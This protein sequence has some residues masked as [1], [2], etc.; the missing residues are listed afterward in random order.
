MIKINIDR[1]MA[2]YFS[3]TGKKMEMKDLAAM[4]WEGK[5]V[6]QTR[7][8]LSRYNNGV[9]KYVETHMIMKICEICYTDPNTLFNYEK[10]E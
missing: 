10:P 5:K 6:E 2:N 3:V 1:A 8:R 9:A 7:Q 4:I